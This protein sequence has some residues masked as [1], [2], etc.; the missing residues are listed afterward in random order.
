MIEILLYAKTDDLP[1][2]I[3]DICLCVHELHLY[4]NLC[5]QYLSVT[6]SAL[7]A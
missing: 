7:A 3:I 5:L 6:E 2:K 4:N 1:L